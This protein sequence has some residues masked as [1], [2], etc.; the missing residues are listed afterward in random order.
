MAHQGKHRVGLRLRP[1]AQGQRGLRGEVQV[2]VQPHGA[3]DRG[4]VHFGPGHNGLPGARRGGPH[5]LLQ[6]GKTP[7]AGGSSHLVAS[8]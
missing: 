5:P 8:T 1:V 4:S 6:P 7:G 2:C 3:A